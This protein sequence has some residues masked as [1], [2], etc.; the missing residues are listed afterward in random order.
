MRSDAPVAQQAEAD[1]LKSSE[2]RFES[3]RGHS[4]PSH[5]P[6]LPAEQAFLVRLRG[7]AIFPP[8]GGRAQ[9]TTAGI[10][11]RYGPNTRSEENRGEVEVALPGQHGAAERQRSDERQPSGRCQHQH[12]YGEI[13]PD[14]VLLTGIRQHHRTGIGDREAG[15]RHHRHL[16]RRPRTTG[17]ARAVRFCSWRPRR[18]SGP[19]RCCSTWCSTS[20]RSRP[21]PGPGSDEHPQ[22]A[23]RHHRLP[24]LHPPQRHR[25][26]SPG[27]NPKRWLNPH[28]WSGNSA[29]PARR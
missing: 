24:G 29:G 20:G 8:H 16:D 6:S 23:G 10:S 26:C 22:L 21:C 2:C 7:S 1:D 5:E 12:E 19:C 4:P 17:P 25:G 18:W 9:A 15:C 3:D 14:A 11:R 28:R 13:C 27:A